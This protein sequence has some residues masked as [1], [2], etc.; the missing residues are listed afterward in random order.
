MTAHGAAPGIEQLVYML[1]QAFDGNDEHSLLGNLRNVSVEDWTWKASPEGR[2]IRRIVEHAGVAKH[3]YAN[4]LFGDASM[5]YAGLVAASP[6]VREPLGLPA[7][8]AW[9]RDG[10]R[11][12]REGML[13][14]SDADLLGQG[15]TH[16]GEVAETRWILSVIIE[17]DV[18]HAGEINH[19]RA[20]RQGNDRWP[21]EPTS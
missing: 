13:T 15:R 8:V 18:Y 16:W 2:S 7:M 17:H 4:H 1:D 12:L 3:L 9:L 21:W 5:T 20:I 6:L 11:A 19:L 14:L 10:H